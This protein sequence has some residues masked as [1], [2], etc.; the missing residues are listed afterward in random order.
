VVIA[1]PVWCGGLYFMQNRILYPTGVLGNVAA[2]APAGVEPIWIEPRPGVRVEAWLV[3]PKGAAPGA[4]LPLAVFFHG[5]AETIDDSIGHAEVYTG[6]GWAALLPEYRGYG[7][8]GGSPNQ[9]ALTADA[10]AFYDAVAARPDIDASRVV[11]HG[12]SLGGGVAC[13]V[14]AKRPCAGLILESTFTS[15]ASFCWGM[16]VP[17]VLCGNPYHNDRV[18]E[19][20]DVPVLVMHGTLDEIIPVAHGRKLKELARHGSYLE[21]PAGHNNFPPDFA[22]YERAVRAFLDG[23]R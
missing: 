1:Y 2:R 3:K 21:M 6:H 13:A 19:K 9:R 8:S 10:V 11:L 12:R 23:V 4:K 7:R 5:N 14:A 15:V 18:V 20:L 16:A 17:P 22:A